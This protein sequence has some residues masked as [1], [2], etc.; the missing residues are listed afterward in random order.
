[1]TTAATQIDWSKATLTMAAQNTKTPALRVPVIRVPREHYE[2]YWPLPWADL[3]RACV[4]GRDGLEP[5]LVMAAEAPPRFCVFQGRAVVGSRT[6]GDVA[7][8][9]S[10]LA[11]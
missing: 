9:L 1:M 2:K 11:S 8:V 5:W 6:Q 3:E 4:D 10:R 7:P